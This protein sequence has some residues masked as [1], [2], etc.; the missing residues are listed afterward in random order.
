MPS[1]EAQ[2]AL[3][4]QEAWRANPAAYV[5]QALGWEPTPWQEEILQ[6][7]AQ[8]GVTAVKSGHAI[9][10]SAL[11]AA[12]AQWAPAVFDSCVV[13]TTAP[14]FRQ[15][16]TVVWGEIHSQ[17][18]RAVLPLGA[19]INQTEFQLGEECRGYGTSTDDP[20]RF[21][22][23]HGVGSKEWGLAADDP[24]RPVVVVIV[25]EAAGMDRKIMDALSTITT[26]PMDRILAIG[27]ATDGDSY[28]AGWFADDSRARTFTV[29]SIRAM[30]FAEKHGIPG[31]CSRRQIE[32]WRAD[33]GEGSPNW[34]GRVLGEFP[35]ES[36][37]SC[38]KLQWVLAGVERW[39]ELAETMDPKAGA[40][41]A[42]LSAIG[43]DVARG[44]NDA[45]SWAVRADSRVWVAERKFSLGPNGTMAV[46]GITVDLRHRLGLKTVGVDDTGLGG[47]VTDRLR[48]Q[49]IPVHGVNFGSKPVHGEQ[50][51]DGS[52]RYRNRRAE[53]WWR[54]REA[55]RL[56]QVLIEPN[57][58]LQG[59]LTAPRYWLGSNGRIELEPKKDIV[60]RL[61]RSPDD[62]DAVVIAWD[63][64]GS[65]VEEL[66]RIDLPS[67]GRR[68]RV[69]RHL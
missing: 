36:E 24:R 46:A 8:P 16:R 21:Q 40:N 62:G 63:V 12:V 41:Q 48:E 51:P 22:G 23:V 43:V 37:D 29:S 26:G 60:A 64:A 59:D 25:D 57:E 15:V 39:H 13:V 38:I 68:D 45:A 17:Q 33:W 5:R 20:N 56:G 69:G 27:N 52:A 18:A 58:R 30:E 7:M 4:L 28:F 34:L 42:V 55:C 65:P 11:A 6:S 50:L 54:F 47:G 14:H 44:G 66:T 31:L 67:R 49:G 2:A 1:A 3:D 10:K 32:D 19:D 35:T 9:G 61:G 53:M